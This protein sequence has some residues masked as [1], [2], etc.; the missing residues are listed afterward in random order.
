[1]N[2]KAYCRVGDDVNKVFAGVE[3]YL[4][5]MPEITVDEISLDFQH[6]IINPESSVFAAQLAYKINLAAQTAPA[7]TS[8]PFVATPP[9]VYETQQYA[10]Y[11]RSALNNPH[12]KK[13]VRNDLQVHPVATH[14]VAADARSAAVLDSRSTTAADNNNVFKSKSVANALPSHHVLSAAV[15]NYVNNLIDYI[16]THPI[17]FPDFSVQ[18]EKGMMKIQNYIRSALN[19][20]IS[21]DEARTVANEVIRIRRTRGL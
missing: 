2:I 16:D 17:N 9:P 11:Q 14:A 7:Q 5:S 4:F 21:R 12:F 10:Q 1:M 15:Q 19:V 13:S 3:S 8:D 20:S 6:T 18:N